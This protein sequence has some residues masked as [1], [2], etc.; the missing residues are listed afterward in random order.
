MSRSLVSLASTSKSLWR[1]S[2]GSAMYYHVSESTKGCF[3]TTNASYRPFRWLMLILFLSAQNA[4]LS[5]AMGSARQWLASRSPS[6]WPG[7]LSSG[8]L[9]STL[10]A[11]VST[12]R[13]SKK[14]R[15]CRTWSKPL[16]PG[17]WSLQIRSRSTGRKRK[18][19]IEKLLQ[20]Y[21]LSIPRPST[22]SCRVSDILE[23]A[24]GYFKILCLSIGDVEIL[25]RIYVAMESQGV[26][27]VFWRP[28]SWTQL[29]I[30]TRQRC[31]TTTATIQT[32]E[33][34]R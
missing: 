25:H 30:P 9:V 13:T 1:C 7:S 2:Q 23:Q 24:Y 17:P 16:T 28:W 14:K 21:H 3:P 10:R 5:F 11:F 32:N 27:R 31:Y 15:A 12:G 22:W 26:E 20:R 29:W 34:F 33:H 4:R 19:Y 6:S 8:N 18:I